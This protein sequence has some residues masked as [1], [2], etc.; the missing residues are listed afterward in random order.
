MW[1]KLNIP[2]FRYKLQ[3][4]VLGLVADRRLLDQTFS[5]GQVTL[6]IFLGEHLIFLLASRSSSFGPL[7]GWPSKDCYFFLDNNC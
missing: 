7:H 1:N 3:L 2:R 4:N 5:F 6:T